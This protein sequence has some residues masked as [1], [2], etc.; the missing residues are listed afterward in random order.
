MQKSN[1]SKLLLITLTT[2]FV[3]TF[4]YTINPQTVKAW[5]CGDALVDSR[6]SK[7]Y[8][9]VLIGSQCWMRENLNVGTKITSCTNGYAGVCTT[10]GDTVQDQGTSCSSIQKYCY[11]DNE[12]NCT[13]YGGLYQWNQAMCGSTTEGAQGICPTGWHIPTDAEQYTLENYLK[14]EGQ[15]CNASRSNTYDCDTAA[16]KLMAGGS[17][18]FI[19]LLAGHRRVT[20]DFDYLSTSAYFWSSLQSSSSAGLRRLYFEYPDVLRVFYSKAFSFSVRCLQ[21][22]PPP[23]IT[24][25][26]A[27]SSTSIRWNFTD[28]ASTETGFKLYDNSNNLISTNATADLSYIDETGLT[29]NTQYTGR[30]IKAYNSNGES[31]ASQTASIYTI[32][33]TP[34]NLQA[35]TNSNNAITLTTDRFTNDTTGQS[36]YY[37]E[38]SSGNNSGW[39]QTNTW[40]DTALACGTTYSYTVKHRN[41]ES[42]QTSTISTDQITSTCAGGNAMQLARIIAQAQQQPTQPPTKEQLIIQIKSKIA[43][44]IQQLILMLQAQMGSR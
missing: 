11:S 42:T 8:S 44:L 29:P 40:Q 15:T 24:T 19:G 2:I 13:T 37:F 6:D 43:E 30:Y 31:Q 39:I 21:H 18:G 4:L 32:P 33:E 1:L 12:A 20:G 17:S 28:T 7:S 35:T 25:P 5:N 16:T 34:T 41:A 23:T 9:T 22:F 3:G 10:G 36:G 38:S 26:Q 27:L 14:D